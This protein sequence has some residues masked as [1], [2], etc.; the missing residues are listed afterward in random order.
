MLKIH[1][2][3]VGH[4]DCT[5]IEHPSGRLTMIDINNSQEYDSDTFE[6][7]LKERRTRQGLANALGIGTNPFAGAAATLGLAP[8]R[9]ILGQAI[10]EY[11]EAREAAKKELADPVA[12][13]KE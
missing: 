2:L 13:M 4:G 1:F 12:F 9:T 3:N 11:A 10:S 7:L 6:E 8:Q 5:I